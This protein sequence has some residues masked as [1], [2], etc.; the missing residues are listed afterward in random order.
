MDVKIIFLNGDLKESIYM[1]QLDGFIAKGQEHL[2]CKLHKS[3]YG[4][5]QTFCSW[6]RR[7]N[8]TIKILDFD[9]NEVEPCAY[10]KK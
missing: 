1:M 5:K 8:K 4:L 7:F 10:K 3:I 2:V 6:N 9:Q